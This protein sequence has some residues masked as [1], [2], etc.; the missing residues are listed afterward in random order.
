MALLGDVRVVVALG[1]LA[2]DQ[3][4]RQFGPADTERR[5]AFSHGARVDLPGGRILI[6]SYHPS[7][8]N[9][10][11]GR[12]TPRMFEGVFRRARRLAGY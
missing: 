10:Q 11:T 5:P 1:K 2:F 3:V 6:G 8:Q 7:R 12:L 4:V 9:T